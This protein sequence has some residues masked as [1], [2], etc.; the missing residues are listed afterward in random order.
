MYILITILTPLGFSGF[1]RRNSGLLRDPSLAL[2]PLLVRLL[3]G[4]M[5]EILSGIGRCEGE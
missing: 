2:S 4:T 5:R 3:G 1:N